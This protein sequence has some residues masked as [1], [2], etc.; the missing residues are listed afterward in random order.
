MPGGPEKLPHA[1]ASQHSQSRFVTSVTP[2]GLLPLPWQCPIC[3]PAK[4]TSLALQAWLTPL[5]RL[6]LCHPAAGATFCAHLG[7]EKLNLITETEK[8]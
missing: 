3:N 5:Q 4:G 1:S 7:R 8:W 2:P 6:L